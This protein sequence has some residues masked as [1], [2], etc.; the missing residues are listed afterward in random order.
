TDVQKRQFVILFAGDRGGDA[1]VH[2]AG[3]ETDRELR[4]FAI[5]FFFGNF[6]RKLFGTAHHTPL[7]VWLSSNTCSRKGAKPQRKCQFV[8]SLGAFAPLREILDLLLPLHTP[9]V[10]GPQMYLCSCN[11]MRTFRPLAAIQSASCCRSTCPQAG[12]IR[13][14]FVRISR[15]LSSIRFL[16]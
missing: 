7:Q 15:S 14:A 6:S 5:R 1:G 16:A 13:T 10:S 2:P 8:L 12:E 4:S 9:F 11:C 3:D